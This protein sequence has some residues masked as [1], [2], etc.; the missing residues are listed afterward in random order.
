MAELNSTFQQNTVFSYGRRLASSMGPA[1]GRP[2]PLCGLT[3]AASVTVP[4]LQSL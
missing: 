1:A 3:P 2:R 4:T